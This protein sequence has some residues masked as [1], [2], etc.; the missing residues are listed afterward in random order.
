MKLIEKSIAK[1]I[2]TFVLPYVAVLG[3]RSSWYQVNYF[4][5]GNT[6]K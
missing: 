1:N 2:K 6:L 4:E 3:I 5:S